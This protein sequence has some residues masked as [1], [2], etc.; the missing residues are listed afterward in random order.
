MA[1]TPDKFTILSFKDCNR[2]KLHSA[3][4]MM[5][6][7]SEFK[8]DG[9]FGYTEKQSDTV[10]GTYGLAKNPGF[11][12]DWIVDGTGATGIPMDVTANVSLFLSTTGYLGEIHKPTNLIVSW[13]VFFANC[14]LTSYNISYMLFNLQGLPIRAKISA[15][16]EIDEPKSL[17]AKLLRKQ[18]PDL[19][20]HRTVK[21][22]ETLTGLCEEIYG[23]SKL[24]MAVAQ[25]NGL[26][27][28]RQLQPGQQ[29]TFPPIAKQA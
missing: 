4:A 14:K 15:T 29:I 10:N 24:Y 22:G 25:A 16:F 18:S 8:I 12:L 13:G 6:N 11:S 23:S 2:T 19:T 17:I 27:D 1:T 20:H 5:L 21:T 7:P 28:F 3:Y 9:S 26:R